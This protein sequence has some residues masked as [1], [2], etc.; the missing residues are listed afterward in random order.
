MPDLEKDK[1]VLANDPREAMELYFESLEFQNM[2]KFYR[3]KNTRGL[4]Q[5]L[6]FRK[7]YLVEED[8][9]LQKIRKI[10]VE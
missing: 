1:W 3:M 6:D 10:L 4:K 5:H 9:K 2:A 8:E 7:R